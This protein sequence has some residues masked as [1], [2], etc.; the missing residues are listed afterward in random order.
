V[1]S[2]GIFISFWCTV[3]CACDGSQTT[4]TCEYGKNPAEALQYFVF[5]EQNAGRERGQIN[6]CP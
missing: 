5:N 4:G 2:I 3:E 6:P 1:K